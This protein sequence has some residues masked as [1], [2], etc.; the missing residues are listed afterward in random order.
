MT[1]KPHQDLSILQEIV[2]SDGWI[3]LVVALRQPETFVGR[4][5]GGR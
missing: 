1:N 5:V 2:I 4:D 3:R